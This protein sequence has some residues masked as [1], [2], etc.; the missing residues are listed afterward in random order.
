M[1]EV[2]LTYRRPMGEQD[3]FFVYFAPVGEPALGPAAFMSRFSGL[4]NPIAPVTHH[5]FDS[6]HIAY[7]VLTFGWVRADK[8]KLDGSIF[9]GRE[10]DQNRWMSIR[11]V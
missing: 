4:D 8:V 10:P 11:F 7:G 3:S 2:A 6:T 5:W 9:N 1:M